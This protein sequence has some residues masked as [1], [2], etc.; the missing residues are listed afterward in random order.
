MNI[1]II[2]KTIGAPYG[3]SQS[4]LDLVLACNQ[5]S[6]NVSLIHKYGSTFPKDIDGYSLKNID[7]YKAPKNFK[8]QNKI[9]LRSL[10]RWVD[11]KFLDSYRIKKLTN[12]KTDLVIVNTITGHDIFLDSN[13]YKNNNSVLVV[14]ESPRHFT[15][16]KDGDI[17]LDK[18]KKLMK[19]YNKFIFVSSNVMNEWKTIFPYIDNKCFYLPNCIHEKKIN[20]I[21]LNKKNKLYESENFNKQNFNIICVASIQYRKGQDIVLDCIDKIKQKV[22]NATFHFVGDYKKNDPYYLKLINHK[23]YKKFK[24]NIIFWGK[25]KDALDLISISNLFLFPT[26][27]EALPRVIL[28]SMA[29]KTPIISTDVDGIPEMLNKNNSILLSIKDTCKMIDSISLIYN[30]KINVKSLIK[31]AHS[32]YWEN[33]SRQK[34]IDRMN[35]FLDKVYDNEV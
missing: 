17:Q 16:K 29:I 4:G 7:V 18:T 2:S 34:Q 19:I 26:R 21:D 20:N 25:R 13:L 11:S 15:F 32:D 22:P 33:F 6:H 8:F 23:N 1:T 10:R 30:K 27:A 28:E 14:R 9:N 5:S 24:Q 31:N 3:A 12:L 35:Y